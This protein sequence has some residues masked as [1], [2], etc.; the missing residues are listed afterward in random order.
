MERWTRVDTPG[1]RSAFE[2]GSTRSAALLIV[3]MAAGAAAI[4]APAASRQITFGSSLSVAATRDTAQNLDYRG[5]DIPT[6]ANGRG[7]IVHVNHDGA[8]ATLW[9]ATLK[10]RSPAAPKSGRVVKIKLEGCAR[11][12]AGAPSTMTQ[13]HFEDLKPQSGGGVTVLKVSEPFVIPLCGQ[14]GAS[15]RTVTTYRP[16][17]LTISRGDFISFEDNGGFDSMFYPSGVPYQVIGSVRSSTMNSFIHA[18]STS[19]SPS[20]TSNHD[21]F[22]RNTGEELML[23][24]TLAASS[25]H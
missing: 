9:N 13:I 19:L 25:R 15:G 17:N 20:Q 1:S 6:I 18:S 3:A 4:P 10:G 24:A 21:G 11:P 23:Q 7:V 14:G 2:V 22:A 16:S 5:T 12:A 8:D